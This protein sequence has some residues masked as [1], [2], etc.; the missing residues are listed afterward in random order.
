V[1]RCARRPENESAGHQR[2]QPEPFPNH[3]ITKTGE[4]LSRGVHF[5][6]ACYGAQKPSY[7]LLRRESSP[8]KSLTVE[9]ELNRFQVTIRVRHDLPTYTLRGYKLRGL[10]FGQG[11]IPVERQEVELPEAASGSETKLEL[12]FTTSAAPTRVQ[13][14]V[15]RPT[16]F[17]A[18]SLNWKP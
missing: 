5:S 3:K 1:S 14:D 11:H 7:E 15:L 17:S 12:A 4:D 9:R 8:I 16:S 10:L 18:Y 6:A 2:M 13:F